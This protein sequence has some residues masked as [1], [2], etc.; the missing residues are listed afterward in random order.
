MNAFENPS[1]TKIREILATPR[2]IAVV[3]CSPDPDR[4][5]HRIAALLKAKGHRVIPVNPSCQEILGERCFASLRAIPEPV[6]MVD[7]FRRPEFVDQIADDA[8]AVG[9]KILWLQLEVIN[10]P[11]AR[12]AHAAGLTV[13]MDRC[14]AIEYRRLF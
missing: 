12:K 1:D 9:A 2:T 10:E 7:V 8:V 14:P 5:S 4:D 13:V 11:A 3:G 6:E